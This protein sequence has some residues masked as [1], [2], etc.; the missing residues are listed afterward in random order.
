M[1][2]LRVVKVGGSMLNWPSLATVLAD[3][4]AAQSPA[5]NVLVVGGGELADVFRR[6]E[7]L[8]Q[9]GEE[10]AHWLCIRAM[11]LNARLVAALLPESRLIESFAAIDRQQAR[12]H[13]L[14]DAEPWLLA[15]EP[16][17]SGAPLE[18][19][20]HVTSDSIAARAAVCLRAEELVLLKSTLPAAEATPNDAA[21]L[22]Y[23]DPFL[24]RLLDEL[25][26]LRCVN[27]RDRHWPELVWK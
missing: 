21:R 8:H 22:G 18:R 17:E 25:P 2:P 24:P 7:A 26:Q 3:W 9:L 27:L 12:C 15:A 6:A 4:L 23:I 11:G 1:S 5:V 13:Y 16:T 20:W 14:L 10:P 19:G